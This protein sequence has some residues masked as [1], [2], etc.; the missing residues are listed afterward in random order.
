VT[1][2]LAVSRSRPPVPCG[3]NYYLLEVVWL[4]EK[5]W[6]SLMWC[7]QQNGSLDNGG[8]TYDAAFH[9]IL[10]TLVIIHTLV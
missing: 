10:W 4:I 8:M 3:A 2:K 1:L 9:Q 5:Q 6:A 7:M